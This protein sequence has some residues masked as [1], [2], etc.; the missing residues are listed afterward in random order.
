MSESEDVH[1]HEHVNVHGDPGRRLG[2]RSPGRRRRRDG[3]RRSSERARGRCCWRSKPALAGARAAR[4]R[5]AF[6]LVVL[7][8]LDAAARRR[9]AAATGD[10]RRPPRAARRGDGRSRRG[11]APCCRGGWP[12]RRSRRSW[13][14]PATTGRSS[15]T[16]SFLYHERDLRLEQRLAD[17]LAARLA[18]PPLRAPRR[19][20]AAPRAA[21]PGRRSSARRWTPPRRRSLMRHLGR[22]RDRQ[23]GA[24][25]RHRADVG[26]DGIAGD[27]IAIAAP[28]GQ[29]GEPHRRAA[30]RPPTRPPPRRCTGCSASRRRHRLR[31]GEFRHHEN[32]PL[33]HDAVIVDEA[34]MVGLPLMEQLVRA[35][36]RRC[37]PGAARRRRSAPRGGAWA[38]CSAIWER[39]SCG[40]P[41]R[42]PPHGPGRPAGAA[43]LDAARAIAPAISADAARPPRRPSRSP[44]GGFACLA[45][46]A[47]GPRTRG[48]RL[49]VRLFVDHWYA[50]WSS[51]GWKRRAAARSARGRRRRLRPARR[52]R[53]P[54]ALDRGSARSRLLTVTRTG[55][56]GADRINAELGRRAART[57]AA[58]AGRRHEIF[59]RHARD[60]HAQRLRPRPASTATRAWCC[61]SLRTAAGRRPSLAAVFARDGGLVPFSAA[62]AARACCRDRVRVHRAQGAGQ[63]ARSRRR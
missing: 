38:A 30:G 60:D 51:P 33:P 54:A 9:D 44:A 17:A 40:S 14:G 8:S 11:R 56:A 49:A 55:V 61:R 62:G 41:H 42:E 5:R 53:R 63:R 27:R 3:A 37:A 12:P 34:S 32:R 25:R 2:A 13:G 23:D 59:R 31:G 20:P 19:P 39:T 50:T 48:G 36:A 52:G 26:G 57:W 6:A 46:E 45:P 35:L 24:H 21:G 28:D 7:A 47:G 58:G 4:E 18:A 16:A 15:S 10:G 1:V 29:G 22:A 43:V